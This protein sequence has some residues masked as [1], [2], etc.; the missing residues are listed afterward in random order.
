MQVRGVPA[1]LLTNVDNQQTGVC[2][3]SKRQSQQLTIYNDENETS[4]S[5]LQI[6]ST[7]TTKIG[8]LQ[9]DTPKAKARERPAKHGAHN[10]CVAT[11]INTLDAHFTISKCL[12]EPGE[13]NKAKTTTL[14]PPQTPRHRDALSKQTPVTPKHRVSITCTPKTNRISDTPSHGSKSPYTEARQLFSRSSN[15][16]ALIG[17][18][19]E[20]SQLLDFVSSSLDGDAGGCLYIS[21][22]PGTG[23]SALLDEAAEKFRHDE[24]MAGYCVINCMSMKNSNDLGNKLTEDLGLEHALPRRD[25][26]D[27]LKASFV[28]EGRTGKRY[29]VVLDEVDQLVDLDL[30][31]LYNLFEWSLHSTSRLILVGIA[32]ALD[33][34]DR[35][36]PR[37]K[38][39]NLKP[40]LLP[41]MP[42]SATQ[43]ADIVTSKLRSLNTDSTDPA[44]IPFIHPAAIQF[45]S[46]KIAAQTGDLRKAFDIC[47]R[48][49]DLAEREAKAGQAS[50]ALQ[51]SPSKHVLVENNNLSSPPVPR[52]TSETPRQLRLTSSL[53]HLTSS[54]APRAT[55]AHVAKV[56]SAVFSNGTTQRLSNLNLQQKAVLCALVATEKNRRASSTSSSFSSTPF[57]TPTSRTDTSSPTIKQLYDI[58][59][60]LCKREKLLHP[61]TSVEFRDVIG[62][63]ETLSLISAVE[64][65]K[66]ASSFAFPLTPSKTKG[67]AKRGFGGLS[68]VV[69]GEKRV[70]SAVGHAEVLS[71]L[72]GPGSEILREILDGDGLV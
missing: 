27:H 65:G 17:R 31:L 38:S 2:T 58:Y 51:T 50:L 59:A 36:L 28:S 57:G 14:S 37:L 10:T 34:T 29:A 71:S 70:S 66:N 25:A 61:L 3:R 46:K 54:T 60:S 26:C 47:R 44:Y 55:I 8:H 6:L 23:K 39:R 11:A 5:N 20:R 69:A 42:Y 7:P 56:T 18:D 30:K 63:L 16:Q 19:D 43:I 33:L 15:S 64:G 67:R 24:R 21:G 41:F 13:K 1:R 35:L 4:K 45:C 52:G 12:V 62:G 22:P 68:V 53:S 32:N 9:L 72:Q 49:V 48:A 40:E